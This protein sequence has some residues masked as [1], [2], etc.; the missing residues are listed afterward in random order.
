[1]PRAHPCAA[2]FAAALERELHAGVGIGRC[3]AGNSERA[4]S[5]E[6]LHEAP[7]SASGGPAPPE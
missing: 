7:P 2:A 4:D 1:M 6:A 5:V 3:L